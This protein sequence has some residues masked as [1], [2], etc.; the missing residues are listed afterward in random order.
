MTKN[1]S[2]LTSP[3]ACLFAKRCMEAFPVL[4]ENI[5][6]F[7]VVERVFQYSFVRYMNSDLSFIRQL[8]IS[9]FPG[10]DR[11]IAVIYLMFSDG[12]VQG[13]KLT[14]NSKYE[15]ANVCAI[16]DEIE[17][18]VHSEESRVDANEG[19]SRLISLLAQKKRVG[20]VISAF[21]LE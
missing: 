13:I 16:A 5:D 17:R 14:G 8:H 19:E 7:R 2:E 10:D 18:L 1:I 15:A 6:F 3:A 11:H 9:A 12:Q 20:L 4:H 21:H